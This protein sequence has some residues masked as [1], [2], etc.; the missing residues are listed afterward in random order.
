MTLVALAAGSARPTERRDG[1]PVA[2]PAALAALAAKRRDIGWLDARMG[3][4]P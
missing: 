2:G 4:K 1:V 3:L